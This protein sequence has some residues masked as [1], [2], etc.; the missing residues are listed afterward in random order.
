[1]AES[2]QTVFDAARV[3]AGV[4][5]GDLMNQ[6]RDGSQEYVAGRKRLVAEQLTTIS[7]AIRQA[8]DKL[9]D[10]DSGFI[11][12]YVDRAADGIEVAGQYV[13]ANDLNNVIDDAGVIARRQPL[14]FASGMFVAG[15]AAA[16][17]LKAATDKQDAR[18]RRRR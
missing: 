13:E 17:F 18:K 6:V 1:M 3:R 9:H 11:A 14:L 8:A 4:Q 7:D 16:Q 12:D 10:A 15:L 2:F 5:V